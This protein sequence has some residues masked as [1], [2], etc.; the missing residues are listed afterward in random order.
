MNREMRRKHAN[1]LA[2]CA[3]PEKLR[4]IRARGSRFAILVPV[5][6]T[7]H[8][9]LLGY[10]AYI[11]SPT[12]N[13]PGHLVAGISYWK[14]GRFDVYRVNP[15]LVRLVAAAPV[16]LAGVQTDWSRFSDHPDIRPEFAL[17]EDLAAANGERILWLVTLARWACIP[18]SLLGGYF[19]CRWSSELYGKTSGLLALVLWCFC[20]NIITNGQLITSDSAA[21]ALGVVACY[22]Y[23]HWIKVPSWT[24]AATSGAMLGLAE[25][26]KSTLLILVALWPLMW[27]AYRWPDRRSLQPRAWLRELGMLVAQMMIALYI[28]NLMYLFDGTGMRLGGF[29]FVSTALGA[30]PGAHQVAPGGGNRFANSWLGELPIPLPRNYVLG[31]DSQRRD[32]EHYGLPSYLNGEFKPNGWWYYYL[33]ALAIKVPLGTWFLIGLATMIGI[34]QPIGVAA[35]DEFVVLCPAVIILAFVSSQTGFSEHM[36]YVLPV[37]PF[38]FIWASRVGK[39]CGSRRTLVNGFVAAALLWSVGSSLQVY[40]HSLSYFNELGGGPLGGSAHLIGSNVDQGQDL[41]KLRAWL[42]AHP[43]ASPLKLAYYGSFDPRHARIEYEWPDSNSPQGQSD[44]AFA[45]ESGWYAISVNFVRGFPRTVYTGYGGFRPLA[46]EELVHFQ[47]IKPVARAGYS[48]FIYH[49]SKDVV[50]P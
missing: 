14:F 20:P 42:V 30:G 3:G 4:E 8:S 45:P 29:R 36:R 32:F 46:Q 23:W 50:I 12:F 26:C 38:V 9:G 7:V 18:F 25:L 40:P 17:G 5:L 6:L 24:K 43:E 27:L 28:I 16:I 1:N 35:K 37:F 13:E 49:I 44:T 47:R 41:L 34:W 11:H 21:T 31:I 33:Y 22:T 2:H 19:C 15:P 48:I 10:G 39:A